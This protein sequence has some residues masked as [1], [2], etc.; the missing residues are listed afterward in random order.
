MESLCCI[1]ASCSWHNLTAAHSGPKW[2]REESLLEILANLCKI[3]N[4]KL[5]HVHKYLFAMKVK[6][7]QLFLL[8]YYVTEAQLW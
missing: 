4:P 2:P 1:L 6:V 7:K 5:S 3:K 8:L